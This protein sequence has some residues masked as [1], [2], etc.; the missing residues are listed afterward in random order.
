[1]CVFVCVRESV[2]NARREIESARTTM[3]QVILIF[4]HAGYGNFNPVR[5]EV[6]NVVQRQAVPE[7]V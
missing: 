6:R 3:I 1:M 2:C 7:C 4:T 5:P